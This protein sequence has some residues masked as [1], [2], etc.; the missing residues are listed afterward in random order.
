MSNLGSA[1]AG[2]TT[3]TADCPVVEELKKRYPGIDFISMHAH[4]PRQLWAS[5][6]E[7]Y[8]TYDPYLDSGVRVHVTEFGIILG[9]ITGDYR[10]GAWDEEKLAEYF[11]QA[12]ATAYSHQAV[13]AFNL[14]SNY[15][16]FTGNPL[17]TE[18]GKPNDEVS[19]DQE[20]APRQA[21][22][23]G[24]RDSGRS[25]RLPVSRVPRILRRFASA[26]F[27][28][29]R[30]HA[31]CPGQQLHGFPAHLERAGGNVQ[32][33]A[34]SEAVKMAEYRQM[35]HGELCILSPANGTKSSE[36]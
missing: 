11:V 15:D 18:E 1:T 31:D 13:R 30:F 4:K 26:T 7:M 32:G 2:P 33:G 27:R 34:S 5:P 28:G 3:S 8:E 25:G 9:E 24:C 23:A 35:R 16:K 19:G 20:P 21:D 12:M 10:S 29:N 14:W 17:F 22:Y 36:I 6:K